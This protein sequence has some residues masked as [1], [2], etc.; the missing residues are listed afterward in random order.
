MHILGISCFYHDAASALVSDGVLTAA[1][2]EERFT[3]KKHDADF[4]INA[5][6]FCLDKAGMAV[7]DLDAVVFYDK[8]FTKFDRILNGYLATAPK[9]YQA[10]RKAVPVWLREKLW[11]PHRIHKDLH[12]HGDILFVEHH[13]SHAAGTFFSSPLCWIFWAVTAISVFVILRGKRRN[14]NLSDPSTHLH[15]SYRHRQHAD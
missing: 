11:L 1:V 7:D 8:P 6:E 13:L 2:Q 3:G 4:P 14:K 9:S 5:I 12:F 15:I 10:F